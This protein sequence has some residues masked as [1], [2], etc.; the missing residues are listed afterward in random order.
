MKNN[1]L[2]L[3]LFFLSTS[4][5]CAQVLEPVK[6]T[7]KAEQ[8]GEN[9]FVLT[10]TAK[11][12]DG[13]Y[14]YSQ[15][16]DE[17][18]P[19]PTSFD[20]EGVKDVKLIG[21]IQ[22]IGDLKEAFE[23]MFEMT[24]RKYGK[25]AAFKAKIKTAN[26][27]VHIEVPVMYM[28][29]NDESCVKLD[30]YFEFDL[31]TVIA[32]TEEKKTTD[33]EKETTSTKEDKTQKVFT[34]KSST[35]DKK[36]TTSNVD[37]KTSST[38]VVEEK[39]ETK[40]TKKEDIVKNTTA[41]QNSKEV[42][43]TTD[44]KKETT[45]GE[46]EEQDTEEATTETS[47]LADNPIIGGEMFEPVH[48]RFD[49]KDLGNGEYLLSFYATMDEGWYIYSQELADGG[50]LPTE[51][52][53]QPN[54]NV[55]FMHPKPKEISDHK[56]EGFD[57]YFEM[58]V[59]KYSKEVTFQQQ[60]KSTDPTTE[61]A[62]YVRFMTCDAERCLP[63]QNVEFLFNQG[64]AVSPV[65]SDMDGNDIDESSLQVYNPNEG[66]SQS[67]WSIFVW[68]FL[69][70]L[71]A[72]LT[73]CVFP[74]IPL[75]VSFFTKSS[76]NKKKG[77]INAAIYALSIVVIYV[78]LGILVTLLFGATAL[79]ELA[80]NPWMNIGFFLIFM[81]FAFSFFGYYELTLPS[82]LVNR[83]DEASDK[84]GLIGIFFM[85]FTL[86]LVSFS[87]TGPII[88][89]LLVVAAEGGIAGPAI[90]MTGFAVALA[91]PFALFAAFPGW[92]NSLPRSG[93]WLNSVKVVLGFIE[94]GLALKFLSNADLVEQWGLIKRETFL[95]IWIIL[96]IGL[97]LYLLGKIKFPHDSPI[98]KLSK[99]RIGMAVLS[100]AFAI[101]LVPG[102]FGQPLS[103]VS[104]FPPPDF[105]SYGYKGHCPLD[106]ACVHDYE[107]GLAIAKQTGKPLMLDFTGWACVNC[108][109]M[110]EQVWSQPEV[111]EKLQKDYIVVSLYVDEK[112]DLPEADQYEYTSNGRKKKVKTV[113]DK[114]AHFQISCFGS[115]AQPKYI[116][117]NH[118]EEMLKK[119]TVGYDPDVSKFVNFLDAGLEN[120]KNNKS[121]AHTICKQGVA[122]KGQP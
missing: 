13:W 72:L 58:E 119:E 95:V 55:S 2:L 78:S 68:G 114:W 3:L 121:E 100:F 81:F 75:T 120:F 6:W 103:L 17:G 33:P 50:P 49:K 82:W 73:P 57:N 61:I 10:F 38:P 118:Q 42:A 56:K 47:N 97:G 63:P 29:C 23:P 48:W 106:L 12:Q 18:G 107:E 90:G 20:F 116:L 9:E 69:G 110:E 102:I 11:I 87:C 117:L 41:T 83:S 39:K 67:Y 44:A 36:S 89:S 64:G 24:V 40:P 98:K 59:I 45:E 34:P 96:L 122:L 74:M 112:A 19:I 60:I 26:P 52:Y 4:T 46:E 84:G 53:F 79:N 111:L 76:K 21:K 104:G 88:G 35:D 99:S 31:K 62:G 85:A 65:V 109:K 77:L 94:V 22:E 51:F 37:T 92:L 7:S 5:L 108:R 105:Y 15:T 14:L 28:S 93:G 113:G 27:N 80:T 86:A 30:E 66:K 25:S 71:L 8:V 16:L 32:P 115:N 70:G 1:L 101:Y 54:G 91:F 43:K